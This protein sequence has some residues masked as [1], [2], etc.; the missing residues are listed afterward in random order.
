MTKN[1]DFKKSK[2]DEKFKIKEEIKIVE[3]SGIIQEIMDKKY[4]GN[5]LLEYIL[6]HFKSVCQG[7]NIKIVMGCI[8][9]R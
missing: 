7:R 9:P 5:M 1:I 3:D 2:Q 8:C 4:P 6:L